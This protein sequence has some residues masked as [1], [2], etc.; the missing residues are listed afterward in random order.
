MKSLPQF[1][2]RRHIAII[3]ALVVIGLIGLGVRQLSSRTSPAN[4]TSTGA[5]IPV[6]A[7]VAARKD[8]PEIVNALGNVQSIDAVSLQPR[9]TGTIEKVEFAP[10]KD[11]KEGQELFLI[12][13]R[14]YQAAL[15]QAKAQLA[16]D[17]GVLSEAQMDLKRY[18]TLESQKSIAAQQAQDQIYVVQQDKG[19]VE[20]D[21]ANVETAQ[22]NLDYC[23]V[24]APISGRVGALLVDRG[25]LVGPQI[26]GQSTSNTSTTSSTTTSGQTT[27][28]DVLVSITQLKPIYVTFSVPQ[29]LLNQIMRN[30]VAA[31]LGV[32][33]FS[34]GRQ[35][36]ATGKVTLVNNQVNTS[37]G[38]IMLQGTFA[39]SNETLWPGE[40]VSVKLILAMRRNVVT[41]PATAVMDGPNGS[42]V[43]VI[44][45]DNTAHRVDVQ[46]AA[47]QFGIAVIAKGISDGAKVVSNGQYRLADGVKVNIE[48]PPQTS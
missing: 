37:T 9:V 48:S 1:V 40:F 6:T 45:A 22:L 7:A 26:G 41:V 30:Q 28:S 10:G 38:T 15:D 21:Q 43:Y 24:I 33:A 42:Y 12:D 2:R 5:A 29:T 8:V 4:G 18:Q 31:P 36:L 27:A 17:E 14:P 23:H 32:E 34:Q 11:V 3:G 25:N 46:V 47:R 35:L 13:P 16:H 20:L 19:T 44:G 39:N